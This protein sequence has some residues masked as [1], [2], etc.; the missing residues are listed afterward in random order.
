MTEWLLLAL[1]LV[2]GNAVFVAAEFSLVTV[3]QAGVEQ[4]V[5]RG[6]RSAAVCCGH[7]GRCR[8]SCPGRSWVSP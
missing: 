2:A 5:K 7:V 8:P 6:E 1:V 4:A 3:D